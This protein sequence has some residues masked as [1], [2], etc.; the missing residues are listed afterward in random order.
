MSKTAVLLLLPALTQYPAKVA[1]NLGR[2]RNG[3]GGGYYEPSCAVIVKDSE[4]ADQAN[5]K[6]V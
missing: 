6:Q 3:C 2:E 4:R 1:E 5:F